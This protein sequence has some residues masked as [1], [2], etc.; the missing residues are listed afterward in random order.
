MMRTSPISI[1]LLWLFQMLL[2]CEVLNIKWVDLAYWLS[3]IGKGLVFWPKICLCL[4]KSKQ[5]YT[6]PWVKNGTYQVCIS[7]G[8]GR[9]QDK[10]VVSHAP[11]NILTPSLNFFENLDKKEEK[12][13]MFIIYSLIWIIHITICINKLIFLV[14]LYIVYC[15]AFKNNLCTS[16]SFL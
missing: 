9:G 11:C 4:K 14:R 16:S 5:K 1:K 15:S 13:V 2:W 6:K 10:V 7:I 8:G 12:N 3:C